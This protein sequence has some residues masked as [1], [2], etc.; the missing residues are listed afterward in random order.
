MQD[1]KQ[2]AKDL[3]A[4]FGLVEPYPPKDYDA[5]GFKVTQNRVTKDVKESVRFFDEDNEKFNPRKDYTNETKC[6]GPMNVMFK[7]I[8]GDRCTCC[9]VIET[10][11]GID[12]EYTIHPNMKNI[13][14]DLDLTKHSLKHALVIFGRE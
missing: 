12:R 2:L 4:W 1:I 5:Y 13:I 6:L 10:R 14:K 3:G 9:F 11:F 7:Q 8:L